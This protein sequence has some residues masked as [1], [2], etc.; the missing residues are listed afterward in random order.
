MH[1]L[2]SRGAILTAVLILAVSVRC[3][4]ME[5]RSLCPCMLVL[6]MSACGRDTVAFIVEDGEGF[7]YSDTLSGYSS[8]RVAIPRKELTLKFFAGFN[9]LG[10]AVL[11]KEGNL[12]IPHG[13]SCPHL[14]MSIDRAAASGE[15]LRFSPVLHKAYCNISLDVHNLPS[16]PAFLPAVRIHGK[17][18]GYDSGLLPLQGPF[19]TDAVTENGRCQIAVPRQRDGSLILDIVS[20]GVVRS[21]ALGDL[22]IDKGYDW[23][24]LDLDDISVFIDYSTPL[25]S[26]TVIPF[27]PALPSEVI[28]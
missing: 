21:F 22:L 14:W 6:D 19:S 27:K 5:D 4:V 11:T 3:S 8:W 1:G 16:M 20:E 10:E 7:S 17:I 18:S 13:S 26:L 28:L 23:T 9:T 12:Q 25:L 15:A 24:A 2:S